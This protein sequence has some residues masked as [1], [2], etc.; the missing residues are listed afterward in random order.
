VILCSLVMV[1]NICPQNVAASIIDSDKLKV[2]KIAI[3]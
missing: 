3:Y 2:L 1:T